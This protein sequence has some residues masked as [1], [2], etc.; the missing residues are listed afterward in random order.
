MARPLVLILGGTGVFGRRIAANLARREELDLIV[1]AR[2]GAA[3]AAFVRALGANR[4]ASLEVDL[5]KADA[6]QRLLQAKPA[7]IVDTVGPFQSRNLAL[8]R[9]C[10]ERGIH[11]VDI[12]DSRA[13]VVEIASLDAA[14]R[15]EHTAIV[16]GA[17]TVPAFTTAIVDD[18][19]KNPQEVVAVEV[20]I[21]PGQ[22]A[23]RGLATASAVLSCCGRPVP[24]ARDDEPAFGWGD[25]ERHAYPAPVG[26]RWL[27]NVDTPE[28]ALWSARYPALESMKI[29]AGLEVGILH[30]GLS[31]LS[32]GVRLGVLPPLARFARPFLRIAAAFDWLGT[33]AG[34]MHVRVVTRDSNGRTAV[35]EAVLV[36]EQGDG[37]QIPAAPAALVVKKLLRLPGYVPLE[38]RGSYPCIG[39]LTREEIMGE[40]RGFAIRY[41]PP[42]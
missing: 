40:L 41:L 20:G 29:R 32:R 16:S 19:A 23:P 18:L 10:A 33:A 24:S 8:P 39:I 31:L 34:A 36:A 26:E 21:T 3:A 6:V 5:A 13:R 27:S 1:A 12:A 37:P 9:R 38:K 14:A 25:L 28:R 42:R 2:D 11:Y 30:L 17:S 22:R 4:A 15:L 7:V 35:R